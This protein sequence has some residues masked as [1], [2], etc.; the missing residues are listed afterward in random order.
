MFRRSISTLAACF[1]LVSWLAYSST[2]HMEGHVP[3]KY[4]FTFNRQHDVMSQK[5]K[6]FIYVRSKIHNLRRRT[7]TYE[8][9]SYNLNCLSCHMR[10]RNHVSLTPVLEGGYVQTRQQV[11][12]VYLWEVSRNSSAYWQSGI[13]ITFQYH[14]H[15]KM[16]GVYHIRFNTA[17]LSERPPKS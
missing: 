9:T 4:L 13:T 12:S 5:I 1:M 14:D 2:L 16:Q 11:C 6:L 7:D 8:F 3:L 15:L 10:L 17:L